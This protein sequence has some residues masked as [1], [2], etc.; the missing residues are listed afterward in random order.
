LFS[1]PSNHGPCGHF[2][3]GLA[4][5]SEEPRFCRSGWVSAR[6]FSFRLNPPFR[7]AAVRNDLLHTFWPHWPGPLDPIPKRGT[8]RD[9]VSLDGHSLLER[10]GNPT[11]SS[12]LFF[13]SHLSHLAPLLPCFVSPITKIAIQTE[14][15]SIFPKFFHARS[16]NRSPLLGRCCEKHFI[17]REVKPLGG[18]TLNHFPL[19]FIF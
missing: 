6:F 2:P 12:R 10:D 16:I 14:S 17:V 18:V 8:K 5:G 15:P 19:L 11:P 9:R 3:R 13:P 7:S 4:L 1:D